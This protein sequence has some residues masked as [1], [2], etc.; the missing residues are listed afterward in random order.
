MLC[1]EVIQEKGSR[2]KCAMTNFGTFYQPHVIAEGEA[3]PRSMDCF[4]NARNDGKYLLSTPLPKI[5]PQ[6]DKK[7]AAF[8]LAE[9]LITLGIIGIVAAMTLPTLIQANKNKEIEAKL[10]KFYSAM[11]QAIMLSES[12]NGDYKYWTGTYKSAG[13]ENF[14]DKYIKPYL[15]AL[16][17]TRFDSYGGDNVMYYFSDGSAFGCKDGGTQLDVYYF[18]NAKNFNKENFAQI[19]EDGTL[20]RTD[21]GVTYFAFMFVNPDNAPRRLQNKK[22]EPYQKYLYT[23]SE[24]AFKQ[25]SFGCTNA[26]LRGYCTVWIQYNGWTIPENYPFKVK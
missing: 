14:L 20:V 7:K 17:I 15:I 13:V 22:F 10:K 21:S 3:C 2:N 6:N 5:R 23:L 8:T 24:S 1:D 12:E 19:M 9:V 26:G 4:A 18:P 25:G 16:K 11:N